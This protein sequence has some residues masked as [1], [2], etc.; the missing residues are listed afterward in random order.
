MVLHFRNNM[1]TDFHLNQDSTN[2]LELEIYD[3]TASSVQALVSLGCRDRNL[4]TRFGH[5]YTF[6]RQYLGRIREAGEDTSN[7]IVSEVHDNN[8]NSK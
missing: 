1:F 7:D 8:E 4:I 2:N 6:I 5:G 3:S